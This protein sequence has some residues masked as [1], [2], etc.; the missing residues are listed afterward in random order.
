MLPA[1]AILATA[2]AGSSVVSFTGLS[3]SLSMPVLI[4]S[5][6]LLGAGESLSHTHPPTVYCSHFTEVDV[7]HRLLLNDINS[8]ITLHAP[9]SK[10]PPSS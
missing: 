3:A 4:V 6:I 8:I 2:T 10:T 5:Y 1:T 7:L 9:G